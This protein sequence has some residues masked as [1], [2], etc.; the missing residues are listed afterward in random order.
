MI[1][2]EE[3]REEITSGEAGLTVTWFGERLVVEGEGASG[4]EE[5]RRRLCLGVLADVLGGMMGA[6]AEL[7]IMAGSVSDVLLQVRD[8]RPDDTVA[9]ER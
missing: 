8:A 6:G 3:M 5:C 7:L 1:L 2:S 9:A 4:R